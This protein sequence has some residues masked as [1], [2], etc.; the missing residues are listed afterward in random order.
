MMR[1]ACAVVLVALVAGAACEAEDSNDYPINPGGGGGGGGG[2][3][4]DASVDATGDGG[5][6]LVGRVCLVSDLRALASCADV[7][8]GGLL[9]TVGD[10]T[11]STSETGAFAVLPPTGTGLVWRVTG[12]DIVP[13]IMELGATPVIPA[14][15]SDAYLDLQ[16]SNGVI[17]QQGQGSIVLRVTRGG[18]PLPGAIVVASPTPQYATFYDGENATV[19]DEDATGVAGLAWLPGVSTGTAAITI[20]PPSGA[21]VAEV[22][23]VEDQ[24][25]TY[26]TV[27]AP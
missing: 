8:A 7:G 10:R 24:A 11:A 18:A 4:R 27:D 16:S 17:L 25:I 3:G 9:V 23:P 21:A 14:I 12:A 6:L 15:R 2:I 5:T 1:R 19:W 26:A 13:S 20:T 22:L